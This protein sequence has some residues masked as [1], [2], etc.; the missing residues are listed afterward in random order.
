MRKEIDANNKFEN[1]V[2]YSYL[3][4]VAKDCKNKQYKYTF[5]L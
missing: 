2:T 3:V 1:I 4:F 5:F